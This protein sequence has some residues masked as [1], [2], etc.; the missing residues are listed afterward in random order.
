[1]EIFSSCWI[2]TSRRPKTDKKNIRVSEVIIT[3]RKGFVSFIIIFLL[4]T[5]IPSSRLG[6]SIITGAEV[7]LLFSMHRYKKWVVAETDKIQNIVLFI[8]YIHI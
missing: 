2:S 6:P 8:L 3:K 1:M 4:Y 7:I 5:E